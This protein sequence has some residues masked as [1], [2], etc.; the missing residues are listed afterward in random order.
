MIIVDV[1][2]TGLDP[3]YYSIVSIGA[4]DFED[5][6]R[7]FYEECRAWDGSKILDE[8]LEVNGFT[9]EEIRDKNKKSLEEIMNEFLDWTNASPERTFAGQNPAFDRDFIN[10]SF[11]RANIPYR[12][13]VRNVDLHS[14]AYA[15]H[16]MKEIPIPMKNAHSDLSLD[17]VAE[18]AGLTREPRPHNALNGA[19][20]EAEAFSR[21]IYGKNLLSEFEEFEVPKYL[22][23]G[24]Q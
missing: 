13:A 17:K 18:Y 22:R 24:Q 12:I 14:V 15:M 20:F 3:K 6:G 5:P 16:R 19:K 4:V 23:Q 2:T 1:E 8:S 9:E 10:D 11:A 21:I 7:V